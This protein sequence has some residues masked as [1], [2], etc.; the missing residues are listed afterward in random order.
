MLKVL[1]LLFIV[2]SQLKPAFASDTFFQKYKR[3]VAN[4]KTIENTKTL[5]LVGVIVNDKNDSLEFVLHRIFPDTLRLQVRFVDGYAIT[6]ITGESGW[7]VDP[8]QKIL[9]PRE[10]YPEEIHRVRSNILNLFS[11][12][13]PNLLEPVISWDFDSGDTNYVSFG[14]SNKTQDTIYYFF[15]K[16]NYSDS[17][18]IIKF[19]HSPYVFK[20]IPKNTFAYF[21]WKV[22]RQI[23][24]FAND[25]KRTLMYIVNININ[26]E[27]DRELFILKRRK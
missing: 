12:V 16:L 21:G 17:Y 1:L 10:M 23:E 26:G 2:W 4:P 14:I 15:N 9:E 5:Q 7:I 3:Y 22:P 6:V 25:V 20:L 27:I 11:F 19:F 18:R 24:I 13:D 8:M